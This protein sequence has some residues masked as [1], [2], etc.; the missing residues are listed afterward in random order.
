MVRTEYWLV[1]S[2]IETSS[3]LNSG[4]AIDCKSTSRCST[5]TVLSGSTC[6]THKKGWSDGLDSSL[7]GKLESTIPGVGNLTWG[8]K[9]GY[10]YK[11]EGGKDVA[12]CTLESSTK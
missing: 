12:I 11:K 9:V 5:D 8:P 1:E 7:E 10:N 4:A 2:R 6:T 3:W